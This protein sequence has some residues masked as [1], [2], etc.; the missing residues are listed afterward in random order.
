MWRC[1]PSELLNAYDVEEPTSNS[2]GINNVF[3]RSFFPG[4]PWRANRFEED[5]RTPLVVCT[6][7]LEGSAP[8]RPHVSYVAGIAVVLLSIVLLVSQ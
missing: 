1:G 2:R 8:A 3:H 7:S 5:N 6:P 4:Q